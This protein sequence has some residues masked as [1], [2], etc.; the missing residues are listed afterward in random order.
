[1]QQFKLS[2]ILTCYNYINKNI[3]GYKMKN[4]ELI[5]AND[6]EFGNSWSTTL[7]FTDGSEET[8]RNQRPNQFFG[9]FG[10]VNLFQDEFHIIAEDDGFCWTQEIVSSNDIDLLKEALIKLSLNFTFKN[11]YKVIFNTKMVMERRT[12]NGFLISVIPGVNT[13]PLIEI[14][15][16]KTL[17]RFDANWLKDLIKVLDI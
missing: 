2:L 11:N 14:K 8:F 16:H 5:E 6:Q 12:S 10:L 4:L 3:K 9:V 17:M 15:L 13:A 1:M 7:K